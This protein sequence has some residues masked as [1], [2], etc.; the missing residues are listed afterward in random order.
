MPAVAPTPLRRGGGWGG[1]AGGAAAAA[2]L[3]AAG[4]GRGELQ[5]AGPHAEGLP[6]LR[7]VQ[8]LDL[9]AGQDEVAVKQLR[10]RPPPLAAA[11]GLQDVRRGVSQRAAAEAH[12]APGAA[13]VAAQEAARL[14]RRR[15]GERGRRQEV[16]LP[17]TLGAAG[18]VVAVGG[19]ENLGGALLIGQSG[20]IC[21]EKSKEKKIGV[22]AVNSQKSKYQVK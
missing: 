7:D 22:D 13:A 2:G 5:A 3:V 1:G 15:A 18:V 9:P 21:R 17:G 8:Q 6:L 10:R 19:E 20:E 4:G 16:Q 14:Q 12:P 11:A